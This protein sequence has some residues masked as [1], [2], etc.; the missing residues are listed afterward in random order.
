M[1]I[2]AILDCDNEYE[3]YDYFCHD[4]YNSNGSDFLALLDKAIILRA[5]EF[6]N[7]RMGFYVDDTTLEKPITKAEFDTAIC[8]YMC[9]IDV[10]KK[11]GFENI[12]ATIHKLKPEV[13]EEMLK[14]L[15]PEADNG[16]LSWIFNFIKTKEL[17]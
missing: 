3:I 15:T 6:N 16:L 17:K 9:A 13:V 8:D 12:D 14:Y 5:I 2:K 7:E 4:C 11:N 10:I 1:Q